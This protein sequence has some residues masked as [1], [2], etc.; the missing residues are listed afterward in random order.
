L[1][2][3]IQKLKAFGAWLVGRFKAFGAWLDK[4]AQEWLLKQAEK[5]LKDRIW[6]ELEKRFSIER[7]KTVFQQ[8][9]GIFKALLKQIGQALSQWLA[10]LSGD[11]IFR[12]LGTIIERLLLHWGLPAGIGFAAYWYF[13]KNIFIGLEAGL[14]VGAVINASAYIKKRSIAFLQFAG[15][16]GLLGYNGYLRYIG[17]KTG[18]AILGWNGVAIVVGLFSLLVGICCTFIFLL[19]GLNALLVFIGGAIGLSDRD[20]LKA[21]G[22]KKRYIAFTLVTCLLG[23]LGYNGYLHM[24]FVDKSVQTTS[25]GFTPLIVGWEGVI[26]AMLVWSLLV[27]A[28]YVLYLIY[29]G[30]QESFTSLIKDF[31]TI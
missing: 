26:A 7:P 1:N 15:L 17:F 4:K 10:S 18:T 24:G 13:H 31:H 12:K 29:R 25:F 19:H 23:L 6:D 5:W 30:V 3:I 8:L 16:L 14:L 20:A 28:C 2:V 21:Q 11:K 27:G 22:K 9:W